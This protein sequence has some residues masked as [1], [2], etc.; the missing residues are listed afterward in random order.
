MS[1]QTKDMYLSLAVMWAA[2][3]AN[4]IISLVRMKLLALLVGPAGIGLLGLFQ[5]FQSTVTTL[6]GLGLTTSSVR[7]L[8]A[9]RSDREVFAKVR[10]ALFVAFFVQGSIAMSAVWLLRG[11]IAARVFN[12]A[13]RGVEVGILSLAI[14]GSMI[15]SSQVTLLQGLR[16]VKD[17]GK[18]MTIGALISTLVG[19][20]VI[21][22]IGDAGIVWFLLL[23]SV[24][25]MVVA[26]HFTRKLDRSG[27]IR[28]DLG[29]LAR[30]WLKMAR[31]G[32]PFML[33]A[34]VA[35]GALLAVRSGIVDRLGLDAAGYFA[36]SWSISLLY[37]NF[38]LQA[39]NTDF[40]PRLSEI[41]LD[42]DKTSAL[43][44]AQIL[45]SLSIGGP[46]ILFT[47]CLAPWLVS[48]LYSASFAPTAELLQWQGAG[49]VLKLVSL[50]LSYVIIARGHSVTF[51]LAEALWNGLFLLLVFGGLAGH[52]LSV[53]GV[54][55]LVAYAVFLGFHLVYLRAR[56]QL[57]LARDTGLV[58]L[59]MFAAAAVVLLL[60]RSFGLYGA[61]ISMVIS[62]AISAL[63]LRAVFVAMSQARTP[64][65][66]WI[67][68]LFALIG[69]PLPAGASPSAEATPSA[70]AT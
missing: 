35:T 38:I 3:S 11:E 49:N 16:R 26:Q 59:M 18:I 65:P 41:G 12:D 61:G 63:G 13:S 17:L 39:M 27:H 57:V 50:P 43:V 7:E 19:L 10:L 51:F 58:A 33:G 47:I 20:A 32:I 60:S 67:Q 69:W 9:S 46:I 29:A 14:L 64:V 68:R 6:A 56:F 24:V 54:A 53:V 2:H 48:L 21:W 25:G 1:A 45:V 5:N 52:G 30:H 40:Y 70:D 31:L 66:A 36:A 55:Y 15:A 23:Q 28:L 4:S 37:V 44:N 42:H 8:A 34:L 22:W 62:L